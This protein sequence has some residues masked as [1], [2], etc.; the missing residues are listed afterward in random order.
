M[1]E[2]ILPDPSEIIPG[3]PAKKLICSYAD[4]CDQ[5]RCIHKVPHAPMHTCIFRCHK[6]Q[7]N[8]CNGYYTNEE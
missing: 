7:Y 6:G 8:M 5:D 1:K 3:K 2:L 4:K